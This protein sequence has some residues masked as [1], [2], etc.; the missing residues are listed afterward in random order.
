M[1]SSVAMNGK[2]PYKQVLT[3]GFVVDAKGHK[4]SKSLGNVITPKEITNSL[5]ADILRLW[6]A[7]VNYTQEITAGDEIFKRQADAY[8]RIRNTS[9]F[10][11]ANINGFELCK[12][13][14]CL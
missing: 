3:H 10:L 7:S 1:M 5:G 11:L 2:A 13:S 4:M 12:T 14:S 6:T 9:R 8:R